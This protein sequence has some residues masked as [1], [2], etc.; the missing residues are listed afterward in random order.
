M[1]DAV[2]RLD[3]AVVGA[4]PVGAVAALGLAAR[5]ARVGVLERRPPVAVANP[6]G[7]DPRTVALS[8]ASRGLLAPLAAW[9]AELATPF[10]AMSVWEESG[11]S[12]LEFAAA[13]GIA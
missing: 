3:V 13:E 10:V 11:T 7:V 1:V 2:A 9:P 4:G 8:E 6:L 12:V 5:G